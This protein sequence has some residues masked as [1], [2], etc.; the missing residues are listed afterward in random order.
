MSGNAS[1]IDAIKP[2]KHCVIL[3]VI[4]VQIDSGCD[5]AEF[6]DVSCNLL[7]MSSSVQSLNLIKVQTFTCSFVD[8]V[9]C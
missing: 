8:R 2:K 3:S 1:R 6:D 5:V 9:T 7:A 4:T